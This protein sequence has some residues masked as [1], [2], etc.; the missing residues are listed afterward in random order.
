[1]NQ[2]SSHDKKA[3]QRVSNRDFLRSFFADYKTVGAIRE[4]SRGV[5]N[6]ICQ[7]ADIPSALRVA[8][9]G[10]GTGPIT[11]EILQQLSVNGSLWGYEVHEPFA[12]HLRETIDDQRFT[13]FEESATNIVDHRRE[14]DL[15]PFD[16]VISTIP[17]SYLSHQQSHDLLR[18][19][20]DTLA[21]DGTFVALQYHP[22]YLPPLLRKHFDNVTRD[23]YLW[24]VPP[25]NLFTA[26]KPR[27]L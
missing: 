3:A 22:T 26:T 11:Q 14:A 21:D 5:A 27:R 18:A 2:A 7:L 13:L 1:M 24:N 8:E 10:C 23:V 6:R 15:P 9:F 16:A 19:V 12:E 17:F 25:A 4:T 20:V